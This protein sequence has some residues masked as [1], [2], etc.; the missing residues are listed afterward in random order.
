MIVFQGLDVFL[1]F[2]LNKRLAILG[3]MR[4]KL[5]I[6]IACMPVQPKSTKSGCADTKDREPLLCFHRASGCTEWKVNRCVCFWLLN[7]SHLCAQSSFRVVHPVLWKNMSWKQIN[8]PK[9]W[10][11][12]SENVSAKWLILLFK[13]YNTR[14]YSAKVS[15]DETTAANLMY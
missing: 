5:L 8:D 6:C 13:L 7:L 11:L 9:K 15:G 14:A 12:E 4:H 2:R 1:L 10:Y 3:R